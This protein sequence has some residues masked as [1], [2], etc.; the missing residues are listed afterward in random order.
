MFLPQINL[1]LSYWFFYEGTS[2]VARAFSTYFDSL[3]NN[4]IQNFF[5]KH[6]PMHLSGLSPYPDFFAFAITLLITGFYNFSYRIEE[7]GGMTKQINSMDI[8]KKII[9]L[10]AIG[11]K[12]SSTM[13]NIFTGINLC[14]LTFVAICGAIKADFHNWSIRPSEVGYQLLLH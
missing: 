9:G 4:Q 14:I 1:T 6:F 8:C 13:N 3:I 11:V 7:L 2:S 12:E 10:L 5:I